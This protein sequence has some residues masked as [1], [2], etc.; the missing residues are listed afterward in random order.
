MR[1]KLYIMIIIITII[2]CA[3]LCACRRT[4]QTKETTRYAV[5]VLTEENFEEYFEI[6]YDPRITEL[7]DPYNFYIISV[8]VSAI[9]KNYIYENVQYKFNDKDTFDKYISETDETDS[10]AFAMNNVYTFTGTT[11]ETSADRLSLPEIHDISGTV[12]IPNP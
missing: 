4:S 11:H 3:S 12:K 7:F 5:I 6:T 9:H 1:R 8:S 2:S 10:L